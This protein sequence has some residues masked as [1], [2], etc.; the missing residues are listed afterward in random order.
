M[1]NIIMND[2]RQTTDE[3]VV[4]DSEA[5]LS[6][7]LRTGRFYMSTFSRNKKKEQQ[8]KIIVMGKN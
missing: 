3:T 7:D 4:V 1:F 8:Q 5:L 2:T 6:F